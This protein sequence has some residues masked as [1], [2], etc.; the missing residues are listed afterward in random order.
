[1]SAEQVRRI[2]PAAGVALLVLLLLGCCGWGWVSSLVPSSRLAGLTIGDGTVTMRTRSSS[3][4]EKTLL[5]DGETEIVVDGKEINEG[6]F[7]LLAGRV[8]HG[9][10]VFTLNPPLGGTGSG[11]G[12]VRRLDIVLLQ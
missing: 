9:R 7:R 12:H 5:V 8:A 2:P 6:E 10:V 3:R 11:D 1:M 4:L